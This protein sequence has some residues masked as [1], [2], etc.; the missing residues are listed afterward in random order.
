MTIRGNSPVRTDLMLRLGAAGARGV[1][2]EADED[3]G[4]DLALR[5][6]AFLVQMESEAAANSVE[7]KAD[8]SR[9][10]LVLE[11][12]RSFAL[13]EGAVLAPALE[14]GLR[15]DGGDAETRTGVEVGGRIRFAD[16]GSGL[17][18]EANARTLVAHEDSGYRE[19]GAG[20]SVR[21]DPGASG[22]GL[23][24]TLAPVW[25]TPSS[26][27]DRLW[28]A[29]DA[30]GLAP[31]EDFEAERRLEGEVGYGFGAFGGRGLMTPYGGL[32][33]TAAG[34]RTWRAGARWSLAPHL[35]MSLDGTRREPANDD[36]PEHA[37]QFRLT[38]RW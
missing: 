38:L 9:L 7:T 34:D 28:S 29:R 36:A 13:G 17:A 37:G 24:V 26:G 16:A 35:A 31:D 22:R 8:A 4:I 1:L 19:W 27:V 5:G 20:G 3:G 2:L 21:L 33:L 30:A 10:R 12:G 25:G 18:V 32:G 23:S 6:D 11:A 14:L 15:H